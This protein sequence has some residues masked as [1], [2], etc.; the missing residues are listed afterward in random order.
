MPSCL[1]WLPYLA[2]W[3]KGISYTPNSNAYADTYLLVDIVPRVLRGV[4]ADRDARRDVA[5][6]LGSLVSTADL[7]LVSARRRHTVGLKGDMFAVAPPPEGLMSRNDID[8]SWMVD[9][10]RSDLRALRVAMSEL[11]YTTS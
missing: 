5:L 6:C 1:S 9:F 8:V 10:S 2:D 4:D 11:E 3:E 7:K